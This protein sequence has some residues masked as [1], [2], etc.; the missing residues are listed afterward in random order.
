MGLVEF[1]AAFISE[2]Y[3]FY[4]INSKSRIYHVWIDGF[5]SNDGQ[6]SED[7]IKPLST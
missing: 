7:R 3:F 1:V 5:T 2:K 4:T 6:V